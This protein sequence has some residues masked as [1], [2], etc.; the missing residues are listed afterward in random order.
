VDGKSYESIGWIAGHG[1][2]T[3][4]NEYQYSDLTA[5]PGIVYYY[6]LKQIDMDGNFAYSNIAS[7]E[8][9]GDKGF[10]LEG[11]YPNPANSQV[12]I[13]V[14]SNI[15][16]IATVIMTDM[17]GRSVIQDEWSLS[18]GYNTNVFDLT[19]MASGTYIVTITSGTVRTSKHLVITK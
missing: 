11:L 19:N 6:R 8:L 2:S 5:T 4:T 7:A 13:G 14:I 10:V 1:N 12:S 18:V 16:T 15:A 3:V 9:T 17:L